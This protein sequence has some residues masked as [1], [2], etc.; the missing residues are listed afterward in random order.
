MRKQKSKY[1]FNIVDVI[2]IA[3]VVALLCF[4]CFKFFAPREEVLTDEVKIQYVLGINTLDKELLD[5]VVESRGSRIIDKLSGE[6]IGEILSV[7]R[8]PASYEQLNV[9]TGEEIY[10]YYPE[11]NNPDDTGV[12]YVDEESEYEK[13]PLYDYYNVLI[14]V[15]AYAREEEGFFDVSGT[16][17]KSGRAIYFTTSSF[18][19]MGCCTS[20]EVVE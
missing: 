20:F 18:T 9:E 15:E 16:Q 19:G 10:E 3:I 8:L 2:V 13:E 6:D 4:L 7:V 5:E 17:I 12:E 14:K 11:I 1:Y